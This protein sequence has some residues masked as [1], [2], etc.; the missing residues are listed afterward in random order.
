VAKRRVRAL[1]CGNAVCIAFE[2]MAGYYNRYKKLYRK[3]AGTA[4]Q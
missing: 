3:K 4:L 1:K 2:L